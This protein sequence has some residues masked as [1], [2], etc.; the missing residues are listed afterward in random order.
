MELQNI[1]QYLTKKHYKGTIH[2]YAFDHTHKRTE[3]I[4][5]RKVS[6]L[7][8]RQEW[9]SGIALLDRLKIQG[10]GN[11]CFNNFWK[12]F[13][14]DVKADVEQW[15]L[16]V[17]YS[18]LNV[19]KF[20]K[21]IL[22]L[23]GYNDEV[24]ELQ[25]KGRAMSQIIQIAD[26]K[27]LWNGIP[28]AIH[29]VDTIRCYGNWWRHGY[30]MTPE[31]EKDNLESPTLPAMI[32]PELW[33]DEDDF[34]FLLEHVRTILV[35]F[36][37]VVKCSQQQIESRL[38]SVSCE[39]AEDDLFDQSKFLELYFSNLREHIDRELDT[40][41]V[42][43]LK[44]D[45]ELGYFEH[46]LSFS[47]CTEASGDDSDDSEEDENK[48]RQ[49]LRL[50]QFRKSLAF[51][52]NI[53]LGMPGA[54][55][56]T[57]LYLLI[58]ECIRQYAGKSETKERDSLPVPIYIPLRSVSS[59]LNEDVIKGAI[60]QEIGYRI[61]EKDV[62]Y[63]EAAFKFIYEIVK[64]G[65]ALLFFDGLNEMSHED[66]K[67]IISGLKNFI[68]M[69]PEESRIFITGR[70]YEYE[71]S[72]CFNEFSKIPDV[73][74]WHLE[75]L[76]FE[77][78]EN[79][80][81]PH[82]RSQIIK[83]GI[84]ELLSSPL[85]LRLF[86]NYIDKNHAATSEES[87]EMPIN[88]G[89]IL[90]AFLGNTLK[91][92]KS[93]KTGKSYL[94]HANQLLKRLATMDHGRMWDIDIVENCI[95]QMP[96]DLIYRLAAA[97]I[98]TVIPA[99]AD[100]DEQVSFSIDTFQ[101]FYRAKHIIDRLYED[102]ELSLYALKDQEEGLDPESSEDFET[103]KLIFEI[104]SSP[105]C[106]QR[107]KNRPLDE[108]IKMAASFSA[109]L[110][111]DFLNPGQTMESAQPSDELDI[112][113]RFRPSMNPRL[114]TL[115]RLTR[116]IP[117]AEDVDIDVKTVMNAKDI[118]ELLAVNN[119]RWFRVKHPQPIVISKRNQIH[120]FLIDLMA[121]SAIIGGRNIWNEIIS[122]Y[123]L[124]TFGILSPYDYN[125][126]DELCVADNDPM[127]KLQVRMNSAYPVLYA[128]AY[129]CRDYIHLYDKIHDLHRY[130]IKRKRTSSCFGI[131]AFLYQYFLCFQ[132]NYAKKHLYHHLVDKYAKNQKDKQLL[133]DINTIL[134]Y[135]GD[136]RFLADNFRF[137]SSGRIRIKELRYVLS[138]FADSVTQKFVL[139]KKFFRMLQL[140][141]KDENL[142]AM[143]IRHF[144]F[145]VGLTPIMKDF[146]FKEGGLKIIPHEEVEGIMDMLPLHSIPKDYIEQNYD[147]DICNLLI[148]ERD[149]V[150][151]GFGVSYTHFGKKGSDF[152]VS[153]NDI[154]EKALIGE[155]CLIGTEEFTVLNDRYEDTVRLYCKIR[156][157]DQKTILLPETGFIC[158]EEGNRQIPYRAPSSNIELDFYLHGEDAV[159]L[160]EL[161]KES[162]K[163]YIG[164][165]ECLME[166]PEMD[167]NKRFIY[168]KF[169]V[170][171]ISPANADAALPYNGEMIFSKQIDKAARS[172][173]VYNTPRRYGYLSN[174]LQL[175]IA[176]V[177]Y[178][179]FGQNK[180]FLWVVTEKVVTLEDM[181]TDCNAVDSVTNERFRICS[182]K[183]HNT[184]YMEFWFKVSQRVSVPSYGKF[185]LLNEN[186]DYIYIPFCFSAK[187]GDGFSFMLRVANEDIPDGPASDLYKASY[188]LGNIPLQLVS[189]DLIN[190]DRRYSMWILKKE[191]R[192]NFTTSGEFYVQRTDD[193][194]NDRRPIVLS[195]ETR[196][197][198]GHISCE[199]ASYDKTNG[200]VT[201][202]AKRP[203]GV[204]G[205][206]KG[207]YN[208]LK[209]LYLCSEHASSTRLK[210]E[211]ESELAPLWVKRMY[212][213]FNIKPQGK[214][215]YL[216]LNESK[217][218]FVRHED[219]YVFWCNCNSDISADED[220]MALLR[221]KRDVGLIF[222]DGAR[223][224]LR[225]M[226][227][228]TGADVADHPM[229]I[230]S[231]CMEEC[232][233]LLES[234]SLEFNLQ[235]LVPVLN[236]PEFPKIF[237]VLYPAYS[238]RYTRD[239]KG[240]GAII[241]PKPVADV[242]AD[243]VILD[244]VLRW[245]IK[246][247][248]EL[249][250]KLLLICLTDDVG[251]TPRLMKPSG[252]VIFHTNSK[253]T[254][255]WYS[256]LTE[257][258]DR[259]H[260]EKYHAEV[261]DK[262]LDEMVGGEH[263]LDMSTLN[264][265]V[266]KSRVC[267]LVAND[268]LLNDIETLPGSR[269]DVCR[270][271]QSDSLKGLEAY[272]LLRCKNVPSGDTMPESHN[273]REFQW[274]DLILM[275]RNH[276]LTLVNDLP[277]YRCLGYKDGFILSISNS[278]K[279]GRKMMVIM[280]ADSEERAYN[281]YYNSNKD[282]RAFTVGDYVNF[283]ATVNYK[284]P[285]KTAA[286]NVV[287]K[288]GSQQVHMAEYIGCTSET[289]RMIYSFRINGADVDITL[290]A[291]AVAKIDL[292]DS[293]LV[294]GQKY[295][296]IKGKK[297]YYL[298][299]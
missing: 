183:T 44:T 127:N 291:K 6:D 22:A 65:R 97:K 81:S 51:K 72:F 34:P 147:T 95:E 297:K 288:G 270:V 229:I 19:E 71:S 117:F 259:H 96:Q 38:G 217:I 233:A 295:K 112:D 199:L 252:V 223:S 155:T 287:L 170:L 60:N 67:I 261:C 48:T 191:G 27:G 62:G 173:S 78:I 239:I 137:D 15:M 230:H 47:H 171:E 198:I 289:T 241:I 116:N 110:A 293:L 138:N 254:P 84:V 90:D 56:T 180:S 213:R 154:E 3:T 63:R 204:I 251:R 260:P 246:Y 80:L 33:G 177:K 7:F 285:Q 98:L 142:S 45:N 207:D 284:D 196:T 102:K 122:T 87:L 125:L 146:L 156:A 268:K 32:I 111:K 35:L 203:K 189:A 244:K 235:I 121:A 75:E 208:L 31:E 144:L 214:R 86:L 194:G 164:D 187:S 159:N 88:R 109:R 181:L 236:C 13:L 298:S 197:T 175:K 266:R 74:I 209:G 262:L 277:R 219:D 57:A 79:Y 245:K 1:I 76:S 143:I 64:K 118:A 290:N 162:T 221:D 273:G 101:E 182:I 42:K 17:C 133:T 9:E 157:A 160:F 46:T 140:K 115:C 92:I 211:K 120:S 132:P 201:F 41:A 272:S 248:K 222:D 58:R 16:Y 5:E 2:F 151:A 218:C 278:D 130:L 168:R 124:F 166:F 113:S 40:Q 188:L 91:D 59:K 224:D 220:L 299:L 50:S 126:D 228:R 274:S 39:N 250:G 271:L 238:V 234:P 149:E 139:S 49:R 20:L 279:N 184:Q 258:I 54:G 66:A 18:A 255:L 123:W 247:I 131:S 93:S 167:V 215:G 263:H 163:V 280:S 206:G 69:L 52:T 275:E 8:T 83:G 77:Q 82:V 226:E 240:D 216:T 10:K 242:E 100:K 210:I 99:R 269:L 253:D 108:S 158:S 281:Y 148:K 94:F 43:E 114:L 29:I 36:L 185:T 25:E 129:N 174:D 23:L 264:F 89:E 135:C 200:K 292:Y 176:Q 225:V 128:L 249:D 257:L 103:L 136:S 237:K 70:K 85:N 106:Y 150:D 4:V 161:S 37:Y 12:L 276:K 21:H 30:E 294:T 286:E 104:G 68:E 53:I 193:N 24:R 178:E 165:R 232:S 231:H 145:R 190:P 243:S 28:D 73:G 26:K 152:M 11:P 227:I 169:R 186:G 105:L 256:N 107:R 134:C 282:T 192:N 195:G 212:I 55:K 61:V 283:F 153:I 119:L 179:V 172:R 265:F 14:V 202:I 296:I 205:S 267:D 141:Y